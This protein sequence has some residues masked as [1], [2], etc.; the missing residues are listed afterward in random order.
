MYHAMALQLGTGSERRYQVRRMA[1]TVKVF[2]KI[3][4]AAN[5]TKSALKTASGV[6]GRSGRFVRELAASLRLER[7][8]VSQCKKLRDQKA[9]TAPAQGLK[10]RS[11]IIQFLALSIVPGVIGAA[12]VIAS[13]QHLLAPKGRSSSTEFGILPR[14]VA[15]NALEIRVKLRTAR[16]RPRSRR[17]TGCLSLARQVETSPLATCHQIYQS[18]TLLAA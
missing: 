3:R 8:F 17:R 2:P 4:R 15:Q 1:L 14:M 9:R 6:I 5:L 7:V 11:A 16:F 18:G 10:K 13:G 12:G